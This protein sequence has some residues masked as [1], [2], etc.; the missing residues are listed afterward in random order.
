MQPKQPRNRARKIIWFNP[1]YNVEVKTNIGKIFLKLVRKH[2]NKRHPYRKLFN[3]NTIKL[4][5]SCTPNIK[6][7][8]KQHNTNTMKGNNE[9]E[10]RECNCR[11]KSDCLLDGKCLSEWIVYEAT[12]TT[13]NTYNIYFG[14][15]EGTFKS[16]YNKH[17][18]SFRLRHYEHET[19][20]SKLL[21][22]LKDKN[23]QYTLKG[24]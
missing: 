23:K 21:W 15:A 1:P 4:S 13:N 6:N 8:I 12:V 7:L 20:L 2:F 11:N 10:K 9:T 5:Y 16:R 22:S 17:T 14:L 19:E 3:T 18:K 24:E